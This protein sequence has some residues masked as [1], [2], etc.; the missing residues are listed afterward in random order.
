MVNQP[1]EPNS[2]T[3][4]FAGDRFYLSSAAKKPGILQPKCDTATLWSSSG[5][6]NRRESTRWLAVR[7]LNA[8]NCFASTAPQNWGGAWGSTPGDLR[9]GSQVRRSSDAN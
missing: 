2:V 6:H 1:L 4:N 5:A 7:R 3:A 9:P 8:F